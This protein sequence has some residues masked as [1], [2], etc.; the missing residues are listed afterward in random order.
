MSV[1]VTKG[2]GVTVFTVNSKEGSSWPLLCQIL[3]TL[4]Y[5]PACSVSQGLRRLQ[6]SSQSALGIIQIMVG[7][8]NIGLGVILID[9]SSLLRWNGTPFWLGGVFI[10]VGIMCILAEK[11]PSPCLVG[12]NVLMNLSGAALAIAGIVLYAVDLANDHFW[13]T[14]NED[15][16]NWRDDYYGGRVTKPPNDQQR[17]RLLEKCKDAKQIAQM[18]MNAL[19]IVLIVLAVLQL[20]VTISSAVLGLKALCKNGKEG[21]QNIQDLEQY[22]P[23]L[24]E[25]TTNPAA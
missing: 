23:L 1:T 8:L 16:Y 9:Y 22:K 18:L 25:V 7:V 24:E 10:A 4:C 6:A 17:D 14:C 15:N 11:F 13:W 2:E 5:S 12:I 3:G 19:D 21:K 20:C